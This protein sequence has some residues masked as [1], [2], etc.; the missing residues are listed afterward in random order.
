MRKKTQI[1]TPTTPAE[2]SPLL[3][4]DATE[5]PP[6]HTKN[7]SLLYHIAQLTLG[8]LTLSLSGYVLSYTAASIADDFN[9]FPRF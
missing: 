8:F 2:R 3:P 5:T 9:A 6:P 7:H 4:N 1:P